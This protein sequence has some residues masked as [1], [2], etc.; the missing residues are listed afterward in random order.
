MHRATDY[1]LRSE[2][3]A[4]PLCAQT[5]PSGCVGGTNNSPSTY[6]DSAEDNTPIPVTVAEISARLLRHGAGGGRNFSQIVLSNPIKRKRDDDDNDGNSGVRKRVRRQLVDQKLPPPPSVV[7]KPTANDR[8]KRRRQDLNEAFEEL[9]KA[10]PR[11]PND[12]LTKDNTLRLAVQYISFLKLKI[13]YSKAL[14]NFC[15][16]FFFHFSFSFS[17][18]ASSG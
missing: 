3:S 17:L 11:L 9:Q 8:E 13:F 2:N 4:V 16:F 12:K 14:D 10:V 5:F 6:S 15:K 7:K 1:S 18:C